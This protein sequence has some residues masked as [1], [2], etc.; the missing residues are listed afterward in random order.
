M[1]AAVVTSMNGVE[2]TGQRP[3]EFVTEADV[4]LI[5]SGVKAREVAIRT[6]RGRRCPARSRS[7]I[8]GPGSRQYSNRSATG[9][10]SLRNKVPSFGRPRHPR[11]AASAAVRDG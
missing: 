4:V 3:M 7:S 5:G 8:V 6:A 1:K 11:R 10:S 2:V 9:T